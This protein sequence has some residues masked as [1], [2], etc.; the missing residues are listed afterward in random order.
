METP[1]VRVTMA[2]RVCRKPSG[3]D[4]LG[5][6]GAELQHLEPLPEDLEGKHSYRGS[7]D[8]LH[9]L[10]DSTCIKVEGEGEWNARKHG[11]TK[12]IP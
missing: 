11:G 4:R 8:P 10:I 5:L 1:L 9:L 7:G 12:G 6:D 3:L 2:R